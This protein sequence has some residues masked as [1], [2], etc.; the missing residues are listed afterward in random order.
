[1]T[2]RAGRAT[3][4][5]ADETLDP[6]AIQTLREIIGDNEDVAFIDISSVLFGLFE[7]IVQPDIYL[8]FENKVSL[9]QIFTVKVRI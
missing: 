5:G 7:G 8:T 9:Q 4:A 1:M 3:G 6:A 2:E